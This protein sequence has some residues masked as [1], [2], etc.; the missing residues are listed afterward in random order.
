MGAKLSCY[1]VGKVFCLVKLGGVL[2]VVYF[3][4]LVFFIIKT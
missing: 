4:G 1:I 3:G 2:V